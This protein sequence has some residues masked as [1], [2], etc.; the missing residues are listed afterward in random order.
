M[1]RE[2]SVPSHAMERLEQIAALHDVFV[3]ILGHDL[4]TPLSSLVYAARMIGARPEDLQGTRRRADQ[5]ERT[6]RR[7]DRLIDHVLA[8]AQASIEGTLPLSL[9]PSDLE[10]L[11]RRSLAELDP[12][13]ASRVAVEANG[14]AT[15]VWDPR[16]IGQVIENLVGNAL[17][18]GEVAGRVRVE[19]DGRNARVVR[20]S[21]HN[22]GAIPA[23][24]LSVLFEPFKA[25]TRMSTGLGLG[26]YVVERIL[27]AH[28][29]TIEVSSNAEQG[30][31]FRVTLPRARSDSSAPSTAGTSE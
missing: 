7:L 30:T 21:V 20:L 5:I 17:E 26:L 16:R 19:I 2:V 14:D 13:S 18:H 1:T 28:A 31:E 4:R 11:T 3:R 27:C 23:D 10:A 25:R 22:G 9:E 6:A 15:G 8:W 12:E 24:T 29:A